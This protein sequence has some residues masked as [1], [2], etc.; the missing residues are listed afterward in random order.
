MSKKKDYYEILGVNRSASP[1][2]IKKAYRKVAL[3]YHPDKNPNN[4]AAEEKFKEAAEAY[5][6]LSNAEKRQRYDRFGPEGIPGG[7]GTGTKMT[8]EDIFSQ[9]SDIFGGTPFGSFF[10]RGSQTTQRG[11]NLRIKLKLTLQEIAQGAEKK[12]K[13][14]RYVTCNA[15]R[16][17]GAQNGTALSTCSTCQGTGEIRKVVNTML[18]QMITAT[19]C[20]TCQGSGQNILTR[21]NNCRGEGRLY[22]EKV[23]RIQVPAGVSQGMQLSMAGKGN[24]P[25]HG[26]IPGDLIIVVEE[27]EDDLLQREGKNLHY[28]LHISF[29]DAALGSDQEVP[30]LSGKA[31]IKLP[32]GTQSGKVFRLRNKGVQDINGSGLG[33]QL[34]H[35]QV[36]TP[37]KLTKEE[38]TKLELLKSSPNF[39]PSPNKED[40]SFFDRIKSFFDA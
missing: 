5:E 40:K 37:Q 24:M 2:E 34:V 33:D 31:K 9:F 22:K 11:T 32:P 29:V 17:N 25:P 27:K 13:V 6:V 14:K 26:G 1:E 18:G 36:W 3:K 16:G 19:T 35:I 8:M 10:G 30:T 28:Q 20:Q 39:T 15:C 7:T 38:R 21:C 4:S 12:I 23:L